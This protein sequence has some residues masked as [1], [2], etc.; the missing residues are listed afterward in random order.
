VE[1]QLGFQQTRAEEIEV[2]E[3]SQL[4]RTA[5]ALLGPLPHLSPLTLQPKTQTNIEHFML[6]PNAGGTKRKLI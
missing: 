2:E 5:A 1:L 3:H 4:Q 6:F